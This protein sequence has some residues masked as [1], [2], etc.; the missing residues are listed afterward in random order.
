MI[1]HASYSLISPD[2]EIHRGE[3]LKR[4]CKLFNLNYT[5]LLR[6]HIGERI[7]H[8]GWTADESFYSAIQTIG[9]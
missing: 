4:L 5:C 9:G 6:V 2:G 1:H 8:K 3:S 7:K